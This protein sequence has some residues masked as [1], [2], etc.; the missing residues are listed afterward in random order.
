MDPG[1]PEYGWGAEKKKETRAHM[2]EMPMPLFRCF[3]S[4][5]LTVQPSYTY[6]THKSH[7]GAMNQPSKQALQAEQKSPSIR[8]HI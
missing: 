3:P 5:D 4:A 7:P 6:T 1:P 2:H 8:D